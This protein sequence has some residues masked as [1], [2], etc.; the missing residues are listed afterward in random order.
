MRLGKIRLGPDRRLIVRHGFVA[1]SQPQE[2]DAQSIM[3][4]GIIGIEP[5]RR[6]E[7]LASGLRPAGFI[8]GHTEIVMRSRAL[9]TLAGRV[10]PQ[11]EIAAIV[12]VPGETRQPQG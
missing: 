9:R 3:L 6:H 10:A 7:G 11:R 1:L 4:F 2:I 5:Q 8:L 12:G